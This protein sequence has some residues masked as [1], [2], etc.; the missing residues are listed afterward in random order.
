MP[1]EEKCK[2]CGFKV[3]EDMDICPKCGFDLAEH[4]TYEK[5]IVAE[6]PEIEESKKTNLVDNPILAFILGIVSVVLS[7]VTVVSA[8]Y[9]DYIIAYII[10]LIVAVVLTYYLSNKP[11]KVKLKPFANV[12]KWLAIFAIGFFIFKIFYDLFGL[13]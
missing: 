6:D 10:L 9:G 8:T 11:A 12:G 7:F 4:R 5:V 3:T 13:I 1:K 2:S